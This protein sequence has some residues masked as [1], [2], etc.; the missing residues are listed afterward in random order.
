M[1]RFGWYSSGQQRDEGI[2]VDVINIEG[3]II[4]GG[5]DASVFNGCVAI[6]LTKT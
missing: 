5:G 1:G 6:E 2:Y 3:S 4:S